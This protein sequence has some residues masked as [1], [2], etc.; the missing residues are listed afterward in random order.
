MSCHELAALR[1]GFMTIL[2]R[3]NIAERLHEEAELG[4]V[5]QQEG[6]LKTLAK[7]S[8]IAMLQKRYTNTL[9]FLE[10]KVTKLLHTNKEGGLPEVEKKIAYLQTLLVLTRKVEM[11]L[12]RMQQDMEIFYQNLEDIHDFVH[13]IYP[14][15]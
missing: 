13:E 12:K 1:L 9:V 10:E 8:N 7:S 15:T 14:G 11:D 2:G 3:D 5:L 4:D 6:P